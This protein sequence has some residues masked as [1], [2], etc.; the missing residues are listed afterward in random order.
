MQKLLITLLLLLT[1]ETSGQVR[2][3]SIDL[4]PKAK[5]LQEGT[6]KNYTGQRT[7]SVHLHIDQSF[8]GKALVIQLTGR[9]GVFMDGKLVG[10]AEGLIKLNMDSLRRIY[11]AAE[12]LSVYAPQHIQSLSIKLHYTD[13]AADSD[14]LIRQPSYYSD[15][16]II[17]VCLLLLIFFVF[18]FRS[19]TNLTLDYLNIIKVFVIHSREEAITTGRIG[20][21]ANILFFM[22]ISMCCSLLLMIA[23]HWGYPSVAMPFPH[24][25]SS[26]YRLVAWWFLISLLFFFLLMAK[27]LLIWIMSK[28]FNFRDLV[29]F[30]YFNFVRSLYGA[31]ILAGLFSAGY[32]I[33][34][35]Q[36]PDFFS[37]LIWGV[38]LILVLSTVFFYFKLLGRTG[39]SVFH[40][41]SYLCGSE[42]IP[43][44]ILIKVLFF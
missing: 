29:R 15:F 28:L 33:G 5:V 18:L 13:A 37:Y 43:L 6:Y 2:E 35:S 32:F 10:D 31:M 14:N 8:A 12:V 38:C 25:A 4:M 22:F 21:S 40:L 20:S 23:A 1:I 26:L 41:F 9:Y 11:G 19:N 3:V 30:Q 17:L 34:Q 36:N 39:S 44:M 27:L 7:Q 24:A 16:V 42:I